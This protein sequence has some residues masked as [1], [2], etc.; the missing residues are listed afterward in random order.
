MT[1]SQGRDPVKNSDAP[2]KRAAVVRVNIKGHNTLALVDS[3]ADNSL[4]NEVFAKRVLDSEV[5]V[6]GAEGRVIGAGGNE[7]HVTGQAD[8]LFQLGT[9]D[10]FHRM[11]MV[12]DLVYHLVL[13]RDFCCLHATVLDDDAGVF[14]IQNQEI[15][16]PTYDE[17]WPKRARLFTS[18]ALTIPARSEALVEARVQSLDGT[19]TFNRGTSWQGVVEP[20]THGGGGTWLIPRIVA[21]VGERNTC[22]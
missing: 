3:G 14:R 21:T 1:G 18:S 15:P 11:T 8:V 4:I 16:L 7:L 10:F 12:R 20:R 22:L 2:Q 9:K 17:L 6:Q 5:L 13:G 19:Q